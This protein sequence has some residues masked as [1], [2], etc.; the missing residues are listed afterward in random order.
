[1][2]PLDREEFNARLFEKNRELERMAIKVSVMERNV[3]E[4]NKQLY[5]AFNIITTLREQINA[6][7]QTESNKG[8]SLD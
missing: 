1:M 5:D 2:T 4:M 8:P 6:L 3:Q 7:T